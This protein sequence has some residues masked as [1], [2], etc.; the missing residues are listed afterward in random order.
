MSNLIGDYVVIKLTNDYKAVLTCGRGQRFIGIDETT[1]IGEELVDKITKSVGYY[2]GNRRDIRPDIE[3][4]VISGVKANFAD[5]NKDVLIG[6]VKDFIK[7]PYVYN[8]QGANI[9]YGDTE[10]LDIVRLHAANIV[11]IGKT[12]YV[13]TNYEDDSQK[14]LISNLYEKNKILGH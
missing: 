8:Q 7:Y 14:L 13:N 4:E 3:V 1:D 10:E 9:I 5:V 6:S 12:Y 11:L 2:L